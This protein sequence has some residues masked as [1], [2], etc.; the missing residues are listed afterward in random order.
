MQSGEGFL[1]VA[2]IDQSELPLDNLEFFID[3][4]RCIG[5]QACMAAC[6]ECDTHRGIPMIHLDYVDRSTSVQTAPVVC[7]HC[8]NPT[9]AMVCPADAIKQDV[10]GVVLSAAHSRCI[11]CNNCTLACPF[12]VPKQQIEMQL[13][14]KCDLCYDR[15]SVGK[16]PMCAAVC[17]SQALHYGSRTKVEAHRGEVPCNKFQFGDQTVKT[18]VNMMT[19]H[20]L[21]TI[22]FDVADFMPQGNLAAFGRERIGSPDAAEDTV[23]EDLPA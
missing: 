4:S 3:P 19:A 17:P 14:M 5:C 6:G 16:K 22:P 13:M 20:G 21:D 8:E 7:M 23:W 2:P 9:C 11:G 18:K 12:G 10:N 1:M 15:S